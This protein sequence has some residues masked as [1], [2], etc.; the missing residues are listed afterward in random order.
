[1]CNLKMTLFYE[2]KEYFLNCP[3]PRIKEATTTP[4]EMI[5]H[6]LHVCDGTKVAC[7]MIE[8]ME[9]DLQKSYKDYWSYETNTAL[10]QIFHKK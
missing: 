4:D 9:P 8:N 7:I 5:E 10:A 6:K 1:M 3:I 2:N